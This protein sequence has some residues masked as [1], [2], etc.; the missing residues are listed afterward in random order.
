[1]TFQAIKFEADIAEKSGQSSLFF[2]GNSEQTVKITRAEFVESK[3]GATGIEFDVINR[4]KQKGYFSLWYIKK[5]GSK[6]E[7]AYKTLQAIMGVTGAANLTPTEMTVKKYDWKSQQ[8]QDTRCICA[9]ELIG[10]VFV[11]LFVETYSLYQGEEKTKLELFAA[12]NKE[13]Q[14]YREQCAGVAPQD[15][16][17][18]H[19][20]MLKKSQ[21]SREKLE[22]EKKYSGNYSQAPQAQ[23]DFN[24]DDIPF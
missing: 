12:Y 23:Q 14:S 4:D 8:E 9:A 1:M 2:D 20:A 19:A 21:K 15:I 18:A 11:G 17:D 22:R 16:E 24:D 3:D 7:Y 6:N 5:D 13:R 10:K